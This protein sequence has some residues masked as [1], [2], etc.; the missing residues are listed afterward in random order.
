VAQWY[1]STAGLLAAR[2]SARLKFTGLSPSGTD[3]RLDSV[4]SLKPQANRSEATML[5]DGM[6]VSSGVINSPG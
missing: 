3:D 6:A 5:E 1:P 2:E 4:G